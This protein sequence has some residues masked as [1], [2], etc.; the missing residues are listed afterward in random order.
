MSKGG[1]Q[2]VSIAVDIGGT[3]TDVVLF[4]NDKILTEKTLTTPD[5]LLVGFFKGVHAVMDRA[6]LKARD[7]EGAIVHATTIVTNALIERK[8]AK[9]AMVFTHG[10]ADILQMRDSRRYDMYDLQIENPVP[11]VNRENVLTVKERVLSDGT[12]SIP[13]EDT[14]VESL[15]ADLTSRNIQSVGVC[16]LFSFKN[17]LHERRIADAIRSKLPNVYISLS[18]DIAPQIREY[19]RASTT[20]VNAYAIPIT[21]PYLE[22][23]SNRLE[24]DG[25]PTKPL[26][27]L[28]SGGVVG[29]KT[30]GRMPV[31]MIESGPAAGAL[32]SAYASHL[33]KLGNLL[34]F[35]M[36]G[37]TAKVCLIQDHKPLVTGR[38][39]IDRVYRFKEGSGLPVAIPSVDMI[40]I[41]AGGGSIARV[42]ELGLLKVGP[43]SAGS[44]PGPV[45]Y[46]GGGTDPTVTDADVV[47]GVIDPEKFLGGAMKLDSAAA[48]ASYEKLGKEL[49]VSGIVAARG[50]YQIV[51][52]TMAG[53]V[54][55]HAADRG[56]DHRGIPILAFGGAGPVHACM[57]A[58]LLNSRTVI[59]PPMASVYS[60]FGS[61]VTP[62]RLDFVRSSLSRLDRLD[63]A[64]VGRLF[65][66]MEQEGLQVLTDAGAKKE[67]ISFEYSADMRYV[68]QQFELIVQLGK[69][70]DPQSTYQVARGNYEN[71][72]LKRYKLI[73]EKVP[74]EV[75]NWRMTASAP[76]MSAPK[77]EISS[78]VA[79][80]RNTHRRMHLWSENQ[81]VPVMSRDSL[82][83]GQ[84]ISGP[85]IIE[86]ADTTLVIAPGW[87]ASLGPFGSV[88]ATKDA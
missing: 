51:C 32:G 61:L 11:L 24:K 10:F 6:G 57:V 88:I 36:G 19:W 30:A 50:V 47:V 38:F 20:S 86:E 85:L 74:V 2:R 64:H 3:F 84:R 68:G 22:G 62:P 53:A 82:V 8:G 12:I 46:R 1:K 41:G 73:Q 29:A 35:D 15:I 48:Y 18:S 67:E 66:E 25:Y 37:T 14:D 58:E 72:Y 45:C 76:A 23:L 63:W 31:R 70:P 83:E 13:L 77:L 34:A 33:L 81:Q 75:L 4:K 80:N 44:K 39:E 9:T 69:R 26:I 71:E 16:L 42:D 54:R 87:Q 27:M 52:E 43:R 60:A 78:R 49:G 56:A 55:A 65:D 40:E 21:Q 79:E 5:D 17:D 7:V 28:S 59:F